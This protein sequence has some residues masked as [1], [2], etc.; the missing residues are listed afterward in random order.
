MIEAGRRFADDEFAKTSWDLKRYLWA[1]ALGCFGILRIHPLED[2]IVMAGAGVS[3]GSLVYASVL[4]RPPKSF[5]SYPDGLRSP[6][7]SQNFRH[8]STR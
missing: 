4:Y 5:Y 1:P 7:G 3:G 8:T 2:V 6:T